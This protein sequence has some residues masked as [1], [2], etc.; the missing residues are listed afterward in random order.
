M[1]VLKSVYIC[2]AGSYFC[3]MARCWG[4]HKVRRLVVIQ[5]DWIFHMMLC[6]NKDMHRLLRPNYG[7]LRY[8]LVFTNLS[9]LIFNSSETRFSQEI[10]RNW[11]ESKNRT[12]HECCTSQSWHF[13][14]QHSFLS[15]WECHYSHSIASSLL[16]GVHR[17]D[18]ILSRP[19]VS[20]SSLL[21]IHGISCLPGN[22]HL[23]LSTDKLVCHWE[24]D[25]NPCSATD[26]SDKSSRAS[27]INP[28]PYVEVL[29]NAG[30][31]FRR[32]KFIR[33]KRSCIQFQSSEAKF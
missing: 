21:I 1:W 31:T 26:R 8:L 20:T 16:S 25:V 27:C 5:C 7:Y 24:T 6:V 4:C 17:P 30:E 28:R 32:V 18:N 22:K 29:L 12:W 11:Y 33:L 10:D 14:T 19:V 9:C 3:L 15:L 23:N 2:W 13:W